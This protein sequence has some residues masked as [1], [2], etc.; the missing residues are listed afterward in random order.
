M[1]ESQRTKLS[2]WKVAEADSVTLL[3][4]ETLRYDQRDRGMCVSVSVDKRAIVMEKQ[5]DI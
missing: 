1:G 4:W 2:A 5:E 3:T